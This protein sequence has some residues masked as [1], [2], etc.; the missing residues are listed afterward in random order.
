[1]LPIE[2]GKDVSWLLVK[3]SE[4]KL[5]RLPIESGKKVK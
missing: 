3:V 4:V 1:M 5:P 2:A